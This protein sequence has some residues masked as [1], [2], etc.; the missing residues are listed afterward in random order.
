MTCQSVSKG[1]GLPAPCGLVMKGPPGPQGATGP[2]GSPNGALNGL[3]DVEIAGGIGSGSVLVYN[4]VLSKWVAQTTNIHIGTG[5]SATNRSVAVGTSASATQ[6]GVAVG[7]SSLATGKGSVVVGGTSSDGGYDNTVVIGNGVT[8]SSAGVWVSGLTTV[9]PG[10]TTNASWAA[11]AGTYNL[12]I[13][14]NNGKLATLPVTL[15]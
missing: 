11:A 13:R 12:V 4:A 9:A 15:S 2:A 10:T 3:E 5:A 14:G 8:A 1:C 7:T 6:S